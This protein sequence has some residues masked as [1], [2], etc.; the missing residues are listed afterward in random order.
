M[1]YV[2]GDVVLMK[3][4]VIA[5]NKDSEFPYLTES[6]DGETQSI[7]TTENILALV[8]REEPMPKPTAVFAVG[9][10]VIHKHKPDWGVGV[11]REILEDDFCKDLEEFWGY[12]DKPCA[13]DAMTLVRYK[14]EYSHKTEPFGNNRWYTAEENL[15]RA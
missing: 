7:L 8:S 1:E 11:V 6:M 9:D 15:V 10:S 12:N 13:R 5:V 2:V 3:V 4:R 14:V